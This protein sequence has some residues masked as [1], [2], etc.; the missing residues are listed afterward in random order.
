MLAHEGDWDLKRQLLVVA[1]LIG[2][3]GTAIADTPGKDWMTI[4][5]AK[6]KL[7]AAGFTT[8]TKIE[9]DDG[10]YEGEGVKGGAVH[11]FYLDPHTGALTKDQTKH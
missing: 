10:H 1:L 11:K 4:D 2:S 7:T 8:V 3:I 9:A 5:Q 6:A